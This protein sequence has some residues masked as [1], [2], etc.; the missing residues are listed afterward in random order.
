LASCIG[1]EE[2]DRAEP[3]P[4]LACPFH[5]KDPSKYNIQFDE[6]GDETADK[7]KKTEYRACAG[8]GFKNI[9]RLK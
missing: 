2:G 9:Q 7:N 8:P 3:I 5:K 6:A 1:N 4:R